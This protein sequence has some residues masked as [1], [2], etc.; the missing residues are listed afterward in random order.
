M[1]RSTPNLGAALKQERKRQG[2]NLAQLSDHS[3]VSRSMLSEIERGNANP[4]FTTLWN[5]TQ[6]LGV[7]IDELASRC[8]NRPLDFIESLSGQ[9]TAKMVSDDGGCQLRALNPLSTATQFEWYELRFE[10]G[11][12]LHS[13]PHAMGTVEHLSLVEGRLTVRLNNNLEQS[14]VDQGTLRYPADVSHSIINDSEQ[15]AMAFLVLQRDWDAGGVAK[16][17]APELTPGPRTRAEPVQAD[18]SGRRVRKTG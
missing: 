17:P 7:T 1:Q 14:V 2:Y 8:D 16:A 3:G 10:A 11:A 4:T 5:I 15:P 9:Q 18:G 6:A 13:E 12:A